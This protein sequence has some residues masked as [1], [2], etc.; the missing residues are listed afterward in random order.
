[1]D[2][3]LAQISQVSSDDPG[4]GFPLLF[5]A[6]IYKLRG[7]EKE[8]AHYLKAASEAPRFDS[9]VNQ[10][11]KRFRM[12][13]ADDPRMGLKALTLY[14]KFPIPDYRRLEDLIGVNDQ[15]FATILNRMTTKATE[16]GG[17]GFSL[18]WE[19]IEHQT[20]IFL[21]KKIAPN[22]AEKIPNYRE[23]LDRDQGL[24]TGSHWQ[25]DE[26]KCNKEEFAE[27][28]QREKIFLQGLD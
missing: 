11:S 15:A 14:S 16:T 12:A 10:L 8:A 9:Y 24:G 20:A 25:F 28:L 13:A 21:L 1:M 26:S 3:A 6:L 2:M 7:R 23:I 27:E 19:P 17:K 22:E 4:N 18:N 5:T